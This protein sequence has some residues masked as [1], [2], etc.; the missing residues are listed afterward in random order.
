MNN[1]NTFGERLSHWVKSSITLK[2]VTILILILL[3][4]IPIEMIK[5]LIRE[6]QYRQH[7]AIEEVS[8]TWANSQMILGPVITLPVQIQYDILNDKTNKYEKRYRT[9]H[10]HILPKQLTV[11]GDVIPDIRKRGIYEVP[12]FTT[13]L[14]IDGKYD[15][16]SI[17]SMIKDQATPLWEEASIS[18]GIS[19]LRGIQEQMLMVLGDQ[20]VIFNPGLYTTDYS[21][22]GVSAKINLQSDS[23][24][25]DL[26]FHLNL[27]LNGSSRLAFVPVG[28]TTEIKL[29]SSWPHPKFDGSFIPDERN[30]SEE[31]FDAYWKVLHLNRPFPQHF[32]GG[33]DL[34]SSSDF[35]VSFYVPVDE[36]QQN[37]R[38][39]KYALMIIVLTFII[40]FFSQAMYPIRIHPIQYILVGFGLVLFYTLLLSIS[41]HLNF[42]ISYIISALAIISLITL[43]SHSIFK[44]KKLTRV[45]LGSLILLYG[46]LYVLLQSKDY[47]LLIGSLGLFVV[48]AAVMY[49]SRNIDWYKLHSK[50]DK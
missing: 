42:Q 3:F 20:E 22:R 24:L 27:K 23:A 38:S 45:M 1:Q 17:K 12:L 37:T 46:L 43:Y 47:A 7:E 18:V 25:S 11:N 35:G 33:K 26:S 40:F 16:E 41:E 28:E 14:N 29:K 39:V 8:A 15:V 49:F 31:G 30:I 48:L 13:D 6:R 21:N 19:D 10:L 2:L 44:Q 5:D 32:F 9:D 36:Y 50:A 34:T 4:L